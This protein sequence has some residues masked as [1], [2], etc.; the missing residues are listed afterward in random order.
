MTCLSTG[1][2]PTVQHLI[3]GKLANV[4]LSNWRVSEFAAYIIARMLSTVSSFFANIIAFKGLFMAVGFEAFDFSTCQ[5]AVA[6]LL[7]HYFT[8]WAVTLMATSW[9]LVTTLL[10][11]F[12]RHSTSW[13]RILT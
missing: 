13:N 6:T 7:D 3:A 9:A 1:M 11:F 8:V 12:T 4:I 5:T 10:Y 2:L